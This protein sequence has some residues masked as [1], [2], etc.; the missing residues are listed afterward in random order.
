MDIKTFFCGIDRGDPPG[1]ADIIG[2][3]KSLGGPKA[4]PIKLPPPIQ[5]PSIGAR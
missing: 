2:I 3:D 5:H 4:T 1:R